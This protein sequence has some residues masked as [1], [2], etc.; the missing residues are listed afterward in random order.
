MLQETKLKI[1][2]RIACDALKDFQVY[3]L[4]RQ[5]TQGGGIAIGIVKDL[6]S[7]L[8]REGK[9]QVEA[10]AV[11][12]VIGE[13]PCSIITAYG[14]QENAPKEK[15]EKFWQFLQ[16]EVLRADLEGNG[17][18][19]QMDGNL[20]AGPGLVKNDPNPVNQNGKMFLEFLEQNPSLNVVNALDLCTGLITRRREL[21]SKT[22]KSVLDFFV[23]NEKL[24]PFLKNMLID[25]ERN[26]C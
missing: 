3:Y 23:V 21:D 19:L 9:D 12:V 5:E 17:L 24:R 8:I 18:I 10:M 20:H 11:Q 7:T 13:L 1:D 15:K 14:P 2:E 4:S 26:Y 22:E 16:E 6:E 25:E